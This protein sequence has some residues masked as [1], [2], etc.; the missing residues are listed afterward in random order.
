MDSPVLTCG[1]IAAGALRRADRGEIHRREIPA[2][3]RQGESRAVLAAGADSVAGRSGA[4]RGWGRGG[5]GVVAEHLLVGGAAPDRQVGGGG[6]DLPRDVEL[7]GLGV[8]AAAALALAGDGGVVAQE[9]ERGVAVV[10]QRVV[11]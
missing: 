11:A 9:A 5:G 1:E 10:R 2:V 7:L 8:V 3:A 6:L 4:R